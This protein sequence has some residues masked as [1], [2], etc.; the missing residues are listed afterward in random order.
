MII[1]AQ[2]QG[3]FA[4]SIE[5]REIAESQW[6][7]TEAWAESETGILS[8]PRVLQIG[9][10]AAR[11]AGFRGMQMVARGAFCPTG[12]PRNECCSAAIS[13]INWRWN[14]ISEWMA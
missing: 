6:Q 7:G 8:D 2:T 13:E 10:Q 1:S 5:L 4:L 12:R 9:E 11:L 3:L 14:G